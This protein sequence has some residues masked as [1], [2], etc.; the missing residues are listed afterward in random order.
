LKGVQVQYVP[1]HCVYI[2]VFTQLPPIIDAMQ[3]ALGGTLR[4]VFQLSLLLEIKLLDE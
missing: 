2:G 4:N 3:C 1:W